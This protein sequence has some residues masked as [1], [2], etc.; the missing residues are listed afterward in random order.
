[1][2]SSC[3]NVSYHA[4]SSQDGLQPRLALWNAEASCVSA[5]WTDLLRL[6]EEHSWGWQLLRTLEAA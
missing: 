1:M 5:G 2:P 6:S 3:M 4:P